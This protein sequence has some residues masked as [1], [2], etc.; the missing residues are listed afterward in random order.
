MVSRTGTG[1]EAGSRIELKV[2][3]LRWIALHTKYEK[4]RL[5]MDEQ[6]EGPFASWVHRHEFTPEG[7]SNTLL[8]DRIEY[9]LPWG[10]PGWLVIPGLANMFTHRHKVTKRLCEN[11]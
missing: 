8:T 1:I 10:L 11:P 6:I 7:E 9:S 3:P 4:N 2:G 5:F